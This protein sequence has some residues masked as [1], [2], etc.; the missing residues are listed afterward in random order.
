MWTGYTDIWIFWWV[1]DDMLQDS[2]YSVVNMFAW[3][4]TPKRRYNYLCLS[5]IVM[6]V[7]A[8]PIWAAPI[9]TW[10]H[11]PVS[12]HSA[13]ACKQ[14]PGYIVPDCSS[15]KKFVYSHVSH[16]SFLRLV[17]FYL[18]PQDYFIAQLIS[19]LCI[20]SVLLDWC[21][22]SPDTM[23][24][25][26]EQASCSFWYRTIIKFVLYYKANVFPATGLI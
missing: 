18:H 10:L 26:L 8:A 19:I 20:L 23:L 3:R 6:C 1:N 11:S 4:W 9:F 5:E 15:R 21:P 14:S 12:W 7:D 2:V 25:F 13:A 22:S 16:F 17:Y 24:V